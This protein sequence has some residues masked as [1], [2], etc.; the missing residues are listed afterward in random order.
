MRILGPAPFRAPGRAFLLAAGLVFACSLGAEEFVWK[1][2]AGDRYRIISTVH[3]DIYIDGE[4]SH[5]AEI[6]NRI[7]STV[8]SL[9]GDRARHR[10][11]FLT[12]EE[13]VFDSAPAG[14]A[15]FTWSREYASVF[16]RDR[17]GRLT[18]GDE[19]FMPV[20]R[21]VP[22]FPEGDL[23]P[24]DT[25]TAPGHEA[26]DFRDSFHIAAPYKIPFTAHYRYLEMREW[27]GRPYPVIAVSYEI[28]HEAGIQPGRLL[29]R[30]IRGRSEELIFWDWD[31][32]QAAY[33]TETFS[34]DIELSDG[35]VF[36]FSGTAEAELA[37]SPDMDREGMAAEIAGE[38][39]GLGA[40]VA[41]SGD[42]VTITLEDI[43]FASE[44]A[45]LLPPEREKLDRIAAVLR[46]RPER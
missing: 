31:L 13:A 21:D 42:G 8:E 5:H 32:G 4:F 33:Y 14:G 18:I 27:R 1:H 16:E 24:G 30:R 38:L 20:V 3:E 2:A 43:Q 40:E 45:E 7:A 10:A 17:R 25:W 11:V 35:T 12:A 29:P 37:E 22:V 15:P 41:V 39:S 28:D 36:T 9:D 23:Q 34:M 44:S 19:Y 6:L 26:H 46:R